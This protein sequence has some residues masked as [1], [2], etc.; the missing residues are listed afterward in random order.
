MLYKI[1]D[2]PFDEHLVN[3][4]KYLNACAEKKLCNENILFTRILNVSLR[5]ADL[6]VFF[7]DIKKILSRNSGWKS[8]KN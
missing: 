6:L 1:T 8:V 7:I 3:M 4:C 2:F 5:L